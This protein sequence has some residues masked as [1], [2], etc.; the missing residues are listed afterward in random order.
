MLSKILIYI[1]SAACLI[2]LTYWIYLYITDAPKVVSVERGVIS[3][4]RGESTFVELESGAIIETPI[5]ESQQGSEV[6]V[7][8]KSGRR[9]GNISYLISKPSK[10]LIAVDADS[11]DEDSNWK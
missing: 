7:V 9:T 4:H 3:S 1:I 11:F 10:I 2:A 8:V 6:L 5:Y